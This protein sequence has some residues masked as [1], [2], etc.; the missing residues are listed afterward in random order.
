VVFKNG[1]GCMKLFRS[2]IIIIVLLITSSGFSGTVPP[3]FGE[4]LVGSLLL[5]VGDA[6]IPQFN[7]VD[8]VSHGRVWETSYRYIPLGFFIQKGRSERNFE[9]SVYFLHDKLYDSHHQVF[10]KIEP[11]FEWGNLRSIGR[12]H[13]SLGGRVYYHFSDKP[14]HPRET[15]SVQIL[16]GGGWFWLDNDPTKNS[17]LESGLRIKFSDS[18]DIFYS[19]VN[20]DV[21]YRKYFGNSILNHSVNFRIGFTVF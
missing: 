21:V 18:Q 13:Y 20:L 9:V 11:Y 14:T 16:L 17:Y 4:W 19:G 6:F 8:T 15:A 10:W 2:I 1:R 3:G 5:S 7:S 12:H